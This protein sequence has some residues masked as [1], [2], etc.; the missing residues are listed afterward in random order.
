MDF[1]LTPDEAQTTARAVVTHLRR[2]KYEVEVE[3]AVADGVPRPTLVGEINDLK[4]MVEAQAAPSLSS[5]V[6]EIVNWANLN[7][8]YGEVYIATNEDETISGR[9][10]KD[11][12]RAGVGLMLV[13][14]VGDVEVS[15]T[16]RNPALVVT[17][18]PTLAL[19]PRKSEV[20]ST[21]RRFN[22]GDRKSALSELC[23]I[24][25]R[26]TDKLCLKL[27]RKGWIDKDEATV[28]GM[29]W[30][31]QINISA[32]DA[33]YTSGKALMSGSAK[34]DLNSFRGARNLI[35]HKARTKRDER[36]RQR[37]FAERMMMGPRLVAELL[38]L[39]R[40][41]K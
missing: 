24:V 30:A 20:M 5:T 11:L 40:R 26:E 32:S 6:T 25:E 1:V 8:V 18:D 7:R 21:V 17:P 39:Q 2:H 36:A 29:D 27:A 3:V 28:E 16:P 38:A 19:G 23:E 15:L 37:Q 12:Q 10:I 13:N 4:V 9:S 33:R 22:D 14:D 34:D 41:V 35:D 31:T